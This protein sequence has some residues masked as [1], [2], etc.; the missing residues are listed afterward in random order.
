MTE[1]Q[2]LACQEPAAMLSVLQDR[3]CDRCLRL[4]ACACCR[5]LWPLLSDPRSQKAVEVAEGLADELPCGMGLH[6][7]WE[8]AILVPARLRNPAKKLAAEAAAEAVWGMSLSVSPKSPGQIAA[9][10]AAEYSAKA[11]EAASA[12]SGDDEREYQADLLRDLFGPLPFREVHIDPA[13]L[14]S[15]V[16]AAASAAYE[17]RVMPLGA[18]APRLLAELADA[19]RAAGC[20]EEAMLSHLQEPLHVRGCHVVDLLLSKG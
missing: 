5:R 7:A 6:D 8:Q 19:L 1:E 13:W 11:A 16:K 17:R 15:A 18:L 4:F 20:G 3:A 2:W 9:E 10:M 12:G 14:T